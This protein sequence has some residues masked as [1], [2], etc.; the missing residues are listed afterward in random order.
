MNNIPSILTDIIIIVCFIL[1]GY[2]L[3]VSN[4]IDYYNKK[5]A[6]LEQQYNNHINKLKLEVKEQEEESERITAYHGSQLDKLQ[7]Y[8]EERI[9]NINNN[10]NSRLLDSERRASAYAN[11]SKADS[12]ARERLASYATQLD[13]TVEEGRQLVGELTETIRL[14]DNQLNIIGKELENTR[15]LMNQEQQDGR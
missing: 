9:F 4:K 6:K 3:G 7:E 2:V 5:V 13:R 10:A 11:M 12:A 14:R 15:S 8:Y 1:V